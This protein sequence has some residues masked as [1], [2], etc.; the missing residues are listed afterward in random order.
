[1]SNTISSICTVKPAEIAIRW[2]LWRIF[3]SNRRG[4]FAPWAASR[5]GHALRAQSPGPGHDALFMASHALKRRGRPQQ[6]QHYCECVQKCKIYFHW[7]HRSLWCVDGGLRLAA[8]A[9]VH[10]RSPADRAQPVWRLAETYHSPERRS[11]TRPPSQTPLS[12]VGGWVHSR[13][14]RAARCS[15][16]IRVR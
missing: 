9:A 5:A 7:R 6:Q 3:H 13:T 11:G 14:R 1:M 8:H 16:S 12:R 4:V 2:R 10:R 15:T